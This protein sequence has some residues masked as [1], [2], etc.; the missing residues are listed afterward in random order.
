MAGAGRQYAVTRRW[1]LGLASV[2]DAYRAAVR[3]APAVEG[4]RLN[5]SL[6]PLSD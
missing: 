3:S 5:G 6:L 2:Y 4:S 1:D